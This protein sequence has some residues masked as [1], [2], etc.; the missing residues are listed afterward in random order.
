MLGLLSLL[1]SSLLKLSFSDS[2]LQKTGFAVHGCNPRP[3]LVVSPCQ[4][5]Y[6]LD[7]KKGISFMSLL[8]TKRNR[9]FLNDSKL[10]W[11]E[12]KLSRAEMADRG[13]G[14]LIKGDASTS[15]AF[16][17]ERCALDPCRISLLSIEGGNWGM[18]EEV[19]KKIRLNGNQKS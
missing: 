1:C 13:G 7:R 5:L 18:V 2:Y 11:P 10:E 12:G 17:E 16:W 15:R 6:L 14:G 3:S 19:A 8:R 4:A 9:C